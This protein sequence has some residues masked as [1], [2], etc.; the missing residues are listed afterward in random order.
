MEK[1]SLWLSEIATKPKL[2]AQFDDH[3][4]FDV[5]IVG[6]G[7]VGLWTSI[8]IKS[9]DPGLSVAVFEKA[10]VGHGASGRN[11]GFAMTW[12]PKV[13]RLLEVAGKDDGL[14]LA[15]ETTRNLEEMQAFL[16]AENVDAEFDLAGWLWTSTSRSH[17]EPWKSVVDTAARYGYQDVFRPVPASDLKRRA[18]SVKHIDAVFE[19]VNGKVHPAK[20]AYSLGEVAIRKGVKI[21]E[22]CETRIERNGSKVSLIASGRAVRADKIVIASN[23]AASVLPELSRSMV[24]VT[25]AIVATA[26]IPERLADIGWTGGETVTDSQTRLN[27]YRTTRSGRVVYGMGVGNLSFGNRLASWVYQDAA[28]IAMTDRNFRRV[29]DQLADVPLQFGWSG[30]IDRTYDGLPLIGTFPASPNVSYGVGWSGNGVGPSR[31]GGRILA[32]LALGIKDRW[33]DNGFIN[34]AAKSFPPE[35]IRYVGGRIV[36]HSVCR[37][38]DFEIQEKSVPLLDRAIAR[39]APA[40][41]E[42]KG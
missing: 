4:P 13:G 32:S 29:Y 2:G 15:S 18:G 16:A 12:W 1:N 33:T 14:W 24:L 36:R 22:N 26:P 11:G 3:G 21:F 30:P 28:G 6:G 37:K 42:D 39:L 27:Y 25:S 20:L 31:I 23:I 7:F 34:R 41:T 9:L 17:R 5:A 10:Q 8:W 35:P 40:G 38:D 19:R